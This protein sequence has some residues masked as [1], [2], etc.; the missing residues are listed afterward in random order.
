M[1]ADQFPDD[2]AMLLAVGLYNRA[3][4]IVNDRGIAL[5]MDGDVHQTTRLPDGLDQL[6]ARGWVAIDAAG[7]RLTESGLWWL[8]RWLK[9]PAVRARLR[10]LPR[11]AG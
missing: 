6:E 3:A 4:V 10:A 5:V 11:R 2:Q 7:V 8:R 9:V 1:T